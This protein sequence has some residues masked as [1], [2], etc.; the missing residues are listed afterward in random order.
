MA[1]NATRRGSFDYGILPPRRG[2]VHSIGW[3]CTTRW[4]LDH[5]VKGL[6]YRVEDRL[7]F[8]ARVADG[9]DTILKSD[10]AAATRGVKIR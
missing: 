6:C 9:Q 5:C 8:L 1:D 4:S 3:L 2:S 7:G 10:R